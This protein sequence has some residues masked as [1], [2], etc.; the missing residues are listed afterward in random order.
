M[1]KYAFNFLLISFL[2]FGCNS[3]TNDYS[4]IIRKGD[5][6]VE[7]KKEDQIKLYAQT[8]DNNYVKVTDINSFE[9]EYLKFYNVFESRE[10]AVVK[11]ISESE[12]GDYTYQSDNYFTNGSLKV[13][14]NYCTFFN[15][16][17]E[18]VLTQKTVN[19][20][21][22]NKL[23]NQKISFFTDNVEVKDISECLINYNCPINPIFD[24]SFLDNK[25]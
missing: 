17:C 1:N 23:I 10:V 6:L 12:S 20:Y 19:Y 18:E 15:S 14:I 5:M 7:S 21:S 3:D 4:K 24:Y 11:V 9:Q 22:E 2:I 16:I 13:L 8:L 25:N